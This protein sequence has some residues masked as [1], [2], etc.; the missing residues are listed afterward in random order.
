M[1]KML[2]MCS[3]AS[4]L[5]GFAIAET[6][7]GRLLDATCVEEAKSRNCDPTG[8]STAFV[9][10]VEGK[11]LKLDDAGNAK[12]VRA[13][14]NRSDREKDPNSPASSAVMAKITGS[15]EGDVIRVDAIQVQ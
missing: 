9:A 5:A 7:S 15:A 2:R 6:Y 3:I 1:Q 11:V 4:L 13:L 8:N 14:R 10:V 12:A